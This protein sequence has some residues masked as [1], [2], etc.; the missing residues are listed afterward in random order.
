[1]DI[2]KIA[3]KLKP[4]M[5]TDVD[6]WLRTRESAEPGLKGLIDK[7]ILSKARTTFGDLDSRILLSL[8][9]PHKARGAIHLGA[10]L[11]EQEKWPAGVSSGEL[12]QN[13]AIFGRSGAGK[14]NVA[15]HLLEQ[16][17]AKKIPFLFLDWKRTARHLLPRL[18]AKV[19]VYTPGRPLAPLVF[20]PF[21]VPPGL[22][23][24]VYINQVVDV[25]ADAFTLGD[26]ARS[27]LQRSVVA[28]YNQGNHAP[29]ASE[30]LAELGK[31][32][33]TGR[34][35][36]WKISATR[37]LESLTFADLSGKDRVS[38]EQL[39]RLLL[40]ENTIIELDALSESGKKF[41]VPLLL[42]WLFYVQL[43]GTEREKL[44][45]AVFVEEAHHLLYRQERRS[46]ETVM[47]ILLRQCREVGLA[48]LVIDQ[49]PHMISSVALGNCYTSICMN[50]KDPSDMN[51]AAAI[52]LV[53]E[54]DKRLFSRLPVGQGVV[55][56][57]DRWRR[58]FL[59]GFPLVKI[60]KGAVTDA[61][62]ARYV[63]RNSTGTARNRALSHE[64]GR[65]SQSSLWDG[66]LSDTALRFIEDVIIHQDDGVKRRYERLS[67]NAGA[68]TRL[69]EELIEDGWLDSE[70]VSVGRTRKVLLRPTVEARKLLGLEEGI[71][72][73]ASVAHEYWK[74]FYARRFAEKGYKIEL[75]AQRA[76]GRVDVLAVKNGERVGIEV[77]TGKSDVVANVRNCLRSGFA[78]VMVVAT[79]E[80]AMRK[81][82]RQLAEAGLLIPT[83]VELGL[84]DENTVAIDRHPH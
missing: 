57:Q 73:R 7:Q 35:G 31:L 20:N 52:S 9:P 18:K 11:Y 17:G 70:T 30:V 38:Q 66:G 26:G 36:G 81:V 75:E 23:P 13:L 16:F 79:D 56:L 1:M 4:L 61:A 39:A 82:E 21:I 33:G 63:R 45:L 74:R 34:A 28:C 76:G 6:R 46:S 19:N 10:V 40:E 64:L 37:A 27:V 55:K 67:L 41:L 50:L 22:E 58:P 42:L 49:H 69:K 47:N 8:P 51:K 32:P 29:L 44:K 77:E 59:V 24:N 68:G 72:L 3:R 14:T 15:F 53:D 78:R 80:V 83:R 65:V 71:E 5:P 84:R 2:E 43:G 62:L 48:M 25:M 54:E 12:L 60:N